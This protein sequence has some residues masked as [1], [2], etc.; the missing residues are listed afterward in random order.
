MIKKTGSISSQSQEKGI[1]KNS[2]GES[3]SDPSGSRA[4]IPANIDFTITAFADSIK[5]RSEFLRQ[6]SLIHI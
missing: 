5:Y 4:V 3:K 2:D 6:L 1:E